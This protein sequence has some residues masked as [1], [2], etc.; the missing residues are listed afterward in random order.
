[1][2]RFMR[3]RFVWGLWLVGQLACLGSEDL[4]TFPRVAGQEAKSKESAPEQQKE[5][6]RAT[7]AEIRKL[8]AS[9]AEIKEPYVGLS[10][11]VSG[12]A[13]A[14]VT[15]MKKIDTMVLTNHRLKTP[16]P[17][18][19]LVQLG[20]EALPH[21]LQ[22]LDDKTPSKLVIE[23]KGALN[24]GFPKDGKPYV[25]K[26]GDVC[27]VALGQIIGQPYNCVEYIPTGIISITS[28]VEDQERARRC[29]GNGPTKK[30][31]LGIFANDS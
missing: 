13:F 10:P 19:R 28:P 2:R 4:P 25:V 3:K 9:L 11:T 5:D 23:P 30:N 14:A 24:V 16:E 21:L 18:K 1:M 26:V 31:R 8:I 17:L 29:G 20:P 22:A 27:Y 6:K 7:E 12:R 15:G